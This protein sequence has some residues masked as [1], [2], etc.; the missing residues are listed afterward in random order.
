MNRRKFFKAM[1]GLLGAALVGKLPETRAMGG[2]VKPGTTY[3]VGER[4]PEVFV[5][6]PSGKFL[7][8][9]PIR[10]RQVEWAEAIRLSDLQPDRYI[11]VTMTHIYPPLS[12]YDYITH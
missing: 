7:Y 4:G 9:Q 1:G 11:T 2:P 5:P 12:D 10:L 8:G 6:S 3:W